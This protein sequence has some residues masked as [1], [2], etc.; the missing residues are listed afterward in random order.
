[1]IGERW[2]EKPLQWAD[3]QITLHG[4]VDR[5][6]ENDVGER[7]VLDYKTRT[8]QAL[9]SK[10]KQLEDHQLPFYGMLSDAPVSCAHY[11]ALEPVKDRTGDAQA[12]HY[13]EWQSAL[14]EQII[15]N[16]Q[17]IA[18]GEALPASGI[19]SVC[20]YCDVRGLC[21]KGAW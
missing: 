21:R 4:R 11:V 12:P 10:F 20:Q 9:S 13:A 3:G 2:F 18:Q 8:Q 5:I 6:D 1:M 19:E 7:A 16:M 14:G 17:A 15:R